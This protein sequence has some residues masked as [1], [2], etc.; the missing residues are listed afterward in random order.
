MELNRQTESKEK[1][2]KQEAAQGISAYLAA[3]GG[4]CYSA[5]LR[6]A[7]A[8]L[9]WLTLYAKRKK[10]ARV[11]LFLQP[12]RRADKH[13]ISEHLTARESKRLSSCVCVL[14]FNTHEWSLQSVE[15]S[16]FRSEATGCCGHCTALTT[17]KQKSD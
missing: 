5:G 11:S 4:C 6:R 14:T 16:K 3:D 13:L 10:R 8:V 2:K 7:L 9:L 1:K 15:D 17:E 12:T